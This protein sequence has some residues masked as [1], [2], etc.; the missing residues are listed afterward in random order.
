MLLAFLLT[1]FARAADAPAA[2]VEPHGAATA[3]AAAAE[4]AAS[5]LAPPPTLDAIVALRRDGQAAEARALLDTLAPPTPLPARASWLYQRGLSAELAGDLSAAEAYYTS[6]MTTHSDVAVEAR[7]RRAVVREA[8]G[9]DAEALDDL[10]A[11]A[12]D[13]TLENEDHL[14]LEIQRG[15][16]ELRNGPAGRGRRRLTRVVADLAGHPDLAWL[17]AKARVALVEDAL[18]RAAALRVGA[19]PRRLARR[20]AQVVA[21][22]AEREHIVALGEAEWSLAATLALADGYADLADDAP[23]GAPELARARIRALALCT[24]G[25][26]LG[27]SLNWES[28]RVTELQVRRQ[29]LLAQMGA[30]PVAPTPADPVPAAPPPTGVAPGPPAPR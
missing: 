19:S 29:A 28:P 12:D 13:P 1:H 4:L 23:A 14:A 5:A 9:Y 8:L 20:Y 15:A 26:D 17:E 18:A 22:E 30:M 16:S 6:A 24:E 27:V 21:A 11:L 10:L 3:G 2:P 7:F 25:V